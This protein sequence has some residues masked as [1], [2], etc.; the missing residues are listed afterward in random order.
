MDESTYTFNI[1]EVLRILRQFK[2]GEIPYPVAYGHL[3]II[4]HFTDEQL[5]KVLKEADDV[6]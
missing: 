4:T 5:H 6:K 3:Q 2:D 1:A